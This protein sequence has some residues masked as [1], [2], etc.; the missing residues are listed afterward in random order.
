[1]KRLAADIVTHYEALC[2]EKPKIVQKAMIVCA[3]RMLAFGV[4]G[5]N[6]DTAQMEYTA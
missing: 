6:R 1:M 3:D 2:S 4:E 5:N